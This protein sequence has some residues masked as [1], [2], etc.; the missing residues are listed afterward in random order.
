MKGD[1]KV[2]EEGIQTLND[3]ISV[4]EDF[5]TRNK[6]IAGPEMTIADIA[7]ASRLLILLVG[8]NWLK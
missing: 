1:N 4:V 6:W 3:T 5:L 2:P 8:L 7:L